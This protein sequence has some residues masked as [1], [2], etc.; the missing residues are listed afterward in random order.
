VENWNDWYELFYGSLRVGI[1]IGQGGAGGFPPFWTGMIE[2]DT[3]LW[4]AA[5]ASHLT[6]YLNLAREAADLAGAHLDTSG[7]GARMKAHYMDVV[8]S[9][10]WRLIDSRGN[11]IPIHCP[12]HHQN[13]LMSWARVDGKEWC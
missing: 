3:N 2:Y 4:D 1:V 7:I 10:D 13:D 8:D 9:P 11:T 6:G 12:M 5:P